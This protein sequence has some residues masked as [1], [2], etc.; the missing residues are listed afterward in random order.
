M[1][2]IIMLVGLLAALSVDVQNKNFQAAGLLVILFG[3][4]GFIDDYV[5]PKMMAGKRGLGWKQKLILEIVG[6]CAAL[7]LSG[8]TDPM[9]MGIG[10]F[11][12]LFF[13]NAYNFADG[14]DGLA[15]GLGAMLAAG[16]ALIA[17]KCDLADLY[18]ILAV[19]GGTFIPFLALNKPPAKVFMGDVGA[20]PIGAVL[21][22][23]V[24][25]LF[26]RGQESAEP[27]P[28][29]T[30]LIVLSVVMIFE[31]VP[32]PLQIASAKLRKGKRLFPFK[33]PIHHG[34]QSSGMP[35]QRVVFLF[36]A[37]QAVCVA[38]AWALFEPTRPFAVFGLG[39]L[40]LG[41]I[42]VGGKKNEP[43]TR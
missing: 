39:L 4:V 15:G 13:S 25:I 1:G 10:L 27:W 36:Y 32:V 21:G 29:W 24:M 3:L 40:G 9:Q 37:V 16:L 42:L 14:L 28:L 33:T 5:V 38:V 12:I 43:A 17:W 7:W 8:I 18:I 22:W 19:L 31:L 23:A 41:L 26:Q 34:F 11:L 30:A 35:E 6:A 20:L 2:G